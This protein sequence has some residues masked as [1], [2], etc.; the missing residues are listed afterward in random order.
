MEL[1]LTKEPVFLSEVIYDGQTEQ[2]IEFDYVLPD[3]YPDIFR[4]LKC[5]IVPS[6]VSYSVS[7]SQLTYDGIAWIKVLYLAENSSRINCVEQRYTYSKTVDLGKSADNHIVKITPKTD[8]CNCRAVSGRRIDVRGAVSCKI[9]VT[10]ARESEIITGAEGMNVQVH[11][12]NVKYCGRKLSTGR[13]F[14]I[15]EEIETGAGG[16][17]ISSIINTDCHAMV[18]D[19]KIISNKVVIKGE[20]KIKAL[21]LTGGDEQ[22]AEVMEASVPIS[23]IMDLDGVTENHFCFVTLKIMDCG[24]DVKSGE[25]NSRILNCD[26]TVDCNIIA[27]QESE[28]TPVDDAYSLDYDTSFATSVFKAESCPKPI[29]QTLILKGTVECSEGNLVEVLDCRCDISNVSMR[30]KSDREI[31]VTGQMNQQI[32]GRL[33]SGMPVFAEKNEPFEAAIEIEPAQTEISFDIDIQ[34]SGTSYS[35][36]SENNVDMRIQLIAR[37]FVYQINSVAV[38]TDISVDKDKPKTKETEYTLKMYNASDGESVWDIAKRFNTLESAVI[39]EN[40]LEDDV[41]SGTAMLLIPLY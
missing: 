12:A 2:G 29:E 24:L 6:I 26:L 5:S 32:I 20:A 40:G 10:S 41:I 39:S 1:K 9:R 7:G 18:S 16:E 3:Y 38:I 22:H 25:E 21:Y 37:G 35:I 15:H 8:Y 30:N 28:I 34:P 27:Q 4:I 13:Q 17:G 19:C 14:A 23:Q 36:G 33:D 11:K 31:A